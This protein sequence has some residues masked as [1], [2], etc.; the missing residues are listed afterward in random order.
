MLRTARLGDAVGVEHQTRTLGEETIVLAEAVVRLE[1][2][3][4]VGLDVH[5]AAVEQRRIV[6]GTAVAHQP[7]TA[8]EPAHEGGDEHHAGI[9]FG[10]QAVELAD[11]FLGRIAS[12]HGVAEERDGGAHH[13]GGR[14]AFARHIAHDEPEH[15]VLL[16]EVVEVAAHILHRH[17]AGGEALGE[18]GAQDAHLDVVGHLHLALHHALVFLRLVQAGHVADVAPHD[19]ENQHDADQQQEEDDDVHQQRFAVDGALGAGEHHLHVVVADL[20]TVGEAIIG[21]GQRGAGGHQHVAGHVDQTAYA[22]LV[23]LRLL[24]DAFQPVQRDVYGNHADRAVLVVVDRQGESAHIAV[25]VFLNVIRPD[26]S[27]VV[28]VGDDALAIPFQ[29]EV[30]VVGTAHLFVDNLVADAM[31]DEFKPMALPGEIVRLEGDA[32]GHHVG[33]VLQHAARE[34]GEAVGVVQHAQDGGP[35][36]VGCVPGV[37]EFEKELLLHDAKLAQHQLVR[38]ILV[39]TDFYEILHPQ[40]HDDDRHDEQDAQFVAFR[41]EGQSQFHLAVLFKW[42]SGF[43]SSAKIRKIAKKNGVNPKKYLF[44]AGK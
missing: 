40:G 15:A 2:D 25:A 37:V 28:P 22:A 38:H 30:V 42:L 11:D 27:A 41:H 9:V 4:D 10:E 14:D 44:G 33:V 3:G 8:V 13:H 12:A 34:V 36:H 5:H 18:V 24:E 43:F 17:Q 26:P 20:H 7:V 31:A 23:G 16:E 39:F 6:A 32:D 29:L 19:V 35:Q 1:A 21:D